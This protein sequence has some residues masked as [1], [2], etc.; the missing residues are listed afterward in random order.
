LTGFAVFGGASLLVL[1]AD[2]P[3]AVIAVRALL[4]AGGAMIMP[5]T[6]SMIRSVFT[7]PRERA[8]ALGVW[9]A[10]SSLGMAVRPIVGVLLL[11]NFSWLAAFL[12]NVPLSVAGLFA[13]LV[14]LREVRDPWRGR[15][16]A[17]AIV[18]SI[19]CMVALVWAIKHFAK[20]GGTDPA[21]WA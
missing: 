6:L 18:Q 19:A 21:A 11:E 17:V 2:S 4:G 14:L 7:D 9:S 10:V 1:A 12:V 15:W 5:T 20:E 13:G 16:D 8:T 3:A